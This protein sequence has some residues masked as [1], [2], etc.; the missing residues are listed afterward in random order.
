MSKKLKIGKEV[1]NRKDKEIG[2]ET[3]KRYAHSH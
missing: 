3:D 1:I 2:T